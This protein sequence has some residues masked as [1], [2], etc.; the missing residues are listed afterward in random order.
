MKNSLVA[1]I[2]LLLAFVVA[3]IAR[4]N[5]EFLFYAATLV[6]LLVILITLDRR[7]D[8]SQTALWSFN[9]WM[10]L[11][12]L[13]G[14]AS[15]GDVRLYDYVIVAWIGDPY[16]ILKYDQFV[17]VFCYFV[18]AI[19]VYE[20]LSRLV[21]PTHRLGLGVVTVLA[22]SGIGGLNEVVE[23]SAVV[24][25]GSTGVGGYTNTA[26]DLVAN[27]L[28]AIAGTVF[29]WSRAHRESR[30]AGRAVDPD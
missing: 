18:I 30:R 22:A 15:I 14:M 16:Q 6:V 23:F 3:A 29:C 20:T 27:S 1:T 5:H 24:F 9:A 17:H 12:L 13:G 19:L 10:L 4:H 7:F 21:L 8:F 26:L 2:G 11:H 28:G 25:L